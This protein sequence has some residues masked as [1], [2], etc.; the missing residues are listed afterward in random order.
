MALNMAYRRYKTNK[1]LDIAKEKYKT[2]IKSVMIRMYDNFLRFIGA[3]A[4]AVVNKQL[5]P[6]V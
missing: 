5:A 2:V 6:L 4:G 3:C 1:I